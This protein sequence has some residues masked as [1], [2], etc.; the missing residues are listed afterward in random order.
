MEDILRRTVERAQDEQ[1]ASSVRAVSEQQLS[2]QAGPS[3]GRQMATNPAA[4]LTSPRGGGDG[5]TRK[6]TQLPGLE[7]T[8]SRLGLLQFIRL[9]RKNGIGEDQAS[10]E[11]A[12]LVFSKHSSMGTGGKLNFLAVQAAVS[13]ARESA[14]VY[15]SARAE[16]SDVRSRAREHTCA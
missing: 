12:E 15:L 10:D 7:S 5:V 9:L 3:H 13:A 16:K 8:S 14:T 1:P 11:E 2:S 6:T 4:E